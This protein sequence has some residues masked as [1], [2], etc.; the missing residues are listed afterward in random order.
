MSHI[1][2]F[3]EFCR[4][5]CDKIKG[6]EPRV[7]VFLISSFFTSLSD[8]SQNEQIITSEYEKENEL[9]L[10]QKQYFGD[11]RL[12]SHCHIRCHYTNK[13]VLQT[14]HPHEV[15]GRIKHIM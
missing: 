4:R 11:V 3:F 1:V 6:N 10:C 7:E 9:L 2:L 14:P 15:Y 8:N 13:G 5:I 12:I